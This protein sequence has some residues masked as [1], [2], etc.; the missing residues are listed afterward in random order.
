MFLKH[1]T[2]PHLHEGKQYRN[3][4]KFLEGE[5]KNYELIYSLDWEDVCKIFDKSETERDVYGNA[6]F[7]G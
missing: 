2:R 3:N 6:Q 1:K 5:N 4:M 7:D